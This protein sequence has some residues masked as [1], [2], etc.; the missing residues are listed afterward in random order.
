MEFLDNQMLWT[1]FGYFVIVYL[2][3]WYAT[4]ST[5]KVEDY[6][7]GGRRFNSVIT[8][9]GAGASDMSGWL[10]LG[11]PGAVYL[12]G[13]SQIWMPV[14]LVTCKAIMS[15]IYSHHTVGQTEI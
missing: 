15:S 8:A 11:L 5:K 4:K 6:I 10:M 12:S 2:V 1:I 7:L 14:G 3:G 9:L 13:I